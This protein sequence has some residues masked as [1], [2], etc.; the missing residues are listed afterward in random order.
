M[1]SPAGIVALVILLVWIA[2]FVPG[3][4]TG[5]ERAAQ[6]RT[7]DRFSENLRVLAIAGGERVETAPTSDCIGPGGGTQRQLLPASDSATYREVTIMSQPDRPGARAKI[8]RERRAQARRRAVLTAVLG[9]VLL[10]LVPV[11]VLTSLSPFTLLIPGALIAAVLVMGR[12]AVVRQQRQD[13]EF[14]RRARMARRAELAN[15][16]AA[17]RP[18]TRRVGRPVPVARPRETTGSI[19]AVA[20]AGAAKLDWGA[21]VEERLERVDARRAAADA[22]SAARPGAESAEPARTPVVG[23]ALDVPLPLRVPRPTYTRKAAAPRWEP[24]PLSAE[25]ERA[26]RTI[27][28]WDAARADDEAIS[29]AQRPAYERE[30][31]A[32]EQGNVALGAAALDG[33]LERRRAVGE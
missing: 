24:A 29:E 10:A 16:I 19:E 14:A 13:A 17:A 5:R 22:A 4:L 21:S 18:G 32:L 3:R 2:Y 1:K 33:V 6:A 9:V 25:I 11:V 28:E 27:A 7:E 15:R 31:I 20:E 23:D 26:S 30:R 12:R 8:M